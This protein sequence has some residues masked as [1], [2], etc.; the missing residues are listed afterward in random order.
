MIDADKIHKIADKIKKRCKPEM[1][2]LFGS[3]ANG[4][5]AEDSDLDFC[6]VKETSQPVHKRG[7]E[8]RRLLNDHSVPFDFIVYT[9]DEY[10]KHKEER[11]SF[12]NSILRDGKI[13]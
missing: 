7:R 4:M 5:P 6:M 12:L 2:I 3:Y 10:K 8:V 1:L 13:L 11:M 9:P